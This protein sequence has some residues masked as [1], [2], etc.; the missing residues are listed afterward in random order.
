MKFSVRDLYEN[1]IEEITFTNMIIKLLLLFFFLL[2]CLKMNCY[3]YL[4]VKK[5]KTKKLN[6]KN[7]IIAYVE[8]L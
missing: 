1:I 8:N 7:L 4:L 6:L 5:D 3:S 2:S